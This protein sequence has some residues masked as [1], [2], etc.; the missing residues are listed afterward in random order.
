MRKRILNEQIKPRPFFLSRQKN[1][2][3]SAKKVLQRSACFRD[4]LRS[5]SADPKVVRHDPVQ[6]ILFNAAP[7]ISKLSMSRFEK[8]GYSTVTVLD[9]IRLSSAKVICVGDEETLSQNLC[10]IGSVQLPE[11][12]LGNDL[13]V[14][15]AAAFSAD[16]KT[17][18]LCVVNAS[19]GG[20]TF[21]RQ[22]S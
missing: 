21:I 2:N 14:G 13:P 5:T 15:W 22:F 6:A 1:S 19:D 17:L 18:I 7:K 20:L 9:I 8:C 3:A 16:R 11:P 10:Q 12:V 4:R